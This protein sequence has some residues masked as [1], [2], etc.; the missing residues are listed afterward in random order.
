MS[1]TE[2]FNNFVTRQPVA[3]LPD[4]STIP[5]KVL[6][7]KELNANQSSLPTTQQQLEQAVPVASLETT[8]NQLN[9]SGSLNAFNSMEN[10]QGDVKSQHYRGSPGRGV[11][12]PLVSL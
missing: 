5:S 4:S 12:H 10:T 7:Q 3:D 11:S 9:S 1:H 2:S 6:T 8:S